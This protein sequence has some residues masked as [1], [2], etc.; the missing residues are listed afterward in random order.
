MRLESSGAMD[1]RLRRMVARTPRRRL[2]DSFAAVLAPMGPAVES[3]QLDYPAADDFTGDYWIEIRY[4]TPGFATPIG[5]G[6]EFRS[7]AMAVLIH[8]GTLFR[9]GEQKWADE[10][11]TDILLYNTQLVDA[12]ETIR[13]PRGFAATRLPE[14]VDV[15]ET[16]GAFEGTA[17]ADDGRLVIRSRAEVR[18]RQI[19]PDGYEGFAAA[20]RAAQDWSGEMYRVEAKEDAR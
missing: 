20:M 15:D 10:R 12:Q 8:N 19:P 17:D 3:V 16:Y 14:A 7:P 18:R 9:A 13:L 4:R 6:L 5:G 1:S 2:T 11:S